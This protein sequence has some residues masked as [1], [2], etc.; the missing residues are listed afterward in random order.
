MS[1]EPLKIFIWKNSTTSLLVD[2]NGL[3]VVTAVMWR[4][5][6]VIAPV[7]GI[8]HSMVMDLERG[9]VCF[10]LRQA[11]S[12]RDSGQVGKIS[13]SAYKRGSS[14]PVVVIALTVAVGFAV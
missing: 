12:S 2:M 9:A 3:P 10:R 7:G 1:S 4:I 14:A 8:N 6:V 11:L 13:R 5:R